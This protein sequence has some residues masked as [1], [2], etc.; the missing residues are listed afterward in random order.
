MFILNS[1]GTVG[2]TTAQGMVR[3]ILKAIMKD[4]YAKD[5]NWRGG[6]D[7]LAF[8]D[9]T[10]LLD[11]I[12][13]ATRRVHSTHTRDEMEA[14]IKTWLKHASDRIKMSLLPNGR[15]KCK[16]YKNDNSRR[17]RDDSNV[18]SRWESDDANTISDNNVDLDARRNSVSS[19]DQDTSN[20]GTPQNNSDSEKWEGP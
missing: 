19:T 11:V 5:A 3:K 16:P 15:S 20:T 8:A 14:A 2:G 4:E 12:F 17:D 9:L 6:G 18:N 1:L 13:Y 7:K 10:N